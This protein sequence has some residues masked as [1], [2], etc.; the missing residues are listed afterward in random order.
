MLSTGLPDLHTSFQPVLKIIRTK[1]VL[2]ELHF[3]DR[4]TQS[5]LSYTREREA[6][7]THA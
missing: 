3:V 4:D 2:L 7:W 1:E 5:K 6:K